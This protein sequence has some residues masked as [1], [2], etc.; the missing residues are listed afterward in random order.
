M[1]VFGVALT[2]TVVVSTRVTAMVV[3]R[4]CRA[5]GIRGLTIDIL[6][7]LAASS[8]YACNQREGQ[9]TCMAQSDRNDASAVVFVTLISCVTIAKPELYPVVEVRLKNWFLYD[10]SG[11]QV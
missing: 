7:E 3:A 2:Q 6:E 1:S 4:A 5:L 11:Y 9:P 8:K 10:G